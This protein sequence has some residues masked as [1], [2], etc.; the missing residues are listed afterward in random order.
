MP[1]GTAARNEDF[2]L[3]VRHFYFVVVNVDKVDEV[4][5]VDEVDNVAYTAIL[6][7]L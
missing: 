3:F 2:Y 6:S 7:T 1:A 5:E 4:D